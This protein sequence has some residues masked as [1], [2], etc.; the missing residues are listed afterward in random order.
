MTNA[1]EPHIS[2]E[3]I[4]RGDAHA[5]SDSIGIGGWQCDKEPSEA[6]WFSVELNRFNASWAYSA[7]ESFR[8]IASLELFTT[9]LCVMLLPLGSGNE[10]KRLV[11]TGETD[12]RGNSFA[13][14]RWSTTKA[15]LSMILMEL[16]VQCRKRGIVLHLAWLPR[17]QNIEADE[18]SNGVTHQFDPR[19]RINC[20]VEELEFEILNELLEYSEELYSDAAAR[21]GKRKLDICPVSNTGT[22]MDS[23][24]THGRQTAEGNKLKRLKETRLKITNPW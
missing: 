22:N 5:S 9:L 16:A 7:G 15:P 19:L 2:N 14:A 11:L 1:K 8:R 4:F 10:G 3:A 13:V 6:A 21:K 20:K 23:L 18:L 12:N 17:L 24:P